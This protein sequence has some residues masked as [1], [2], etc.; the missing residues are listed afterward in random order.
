MSFTFSSSLRLA[1]LAAW[2]ANPCMTVATKRA[3][4]VASA[5]GGAAKLYGDGTPCAVFGVKID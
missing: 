5:R 2:T 4:P 1:P 3:S